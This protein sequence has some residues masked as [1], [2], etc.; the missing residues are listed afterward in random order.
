[1]AIVYSVVAQQSLGELLAGVGVPGFL[2]SG[3]YIAYITVRC[4]IDP[5]LG[6]PLPVKERV[7]FMEKLK[8]LQGTIAP[9]LLICLALGVIFFGIATPSK[10]PA[11]E[12]SAPCSSARSTGVL[13]GSQSGKHPAPR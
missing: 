6:P 7:S 1:M 3:L 4:V 9:I 8:L 11:S 5:T 10:R 12:R 13:T 2:L